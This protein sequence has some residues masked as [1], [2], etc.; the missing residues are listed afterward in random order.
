MRQVKIPAWVGA[1]Q[2]QLTNSFFYITLFN[3]AMLSVTAWGSVGPSIQ[4][5]WP[6]AKFW[7][8]AVLAFVVLIVIMLLDYRFMYPVRQGFINEQA[9]KH[10]NPAMDELWS[11]SRRLT[12]I[13]KEL[14]IEKDITDTAVSR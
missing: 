7:M 8:F 2:V 12:F 5:A 4:V 1:F 10:E 3:T 13:E 14:G 11:I 6:W 9:C